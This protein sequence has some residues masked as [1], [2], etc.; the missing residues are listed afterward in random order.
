M[1]EPGDH[2]FEPTRPREWPTKPGPLRGLAILAIVA[3]TTY[4][5]AARVETGKD[6]FVT[7]LGKIEVTARLVESPDQFPNLG[8]YRYTYVIKYKVLAVHRQDP[9]ANYKLAPGDEIFVGHYKPWLP[10]SE[11]K[12]SDWD[13]GPLGGKLTRFAVGEAHRLALD[14]DLQNLAPSGVL[15]YCYP[16]ATNRFFALWTNPTT[17]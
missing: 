3:L 16:Q 12:D 5:L 17:Y 11:I 1:N 10:R 7:T 8:A 6:E 13:D 2:P 4:L 9:D 14:Y 15:D